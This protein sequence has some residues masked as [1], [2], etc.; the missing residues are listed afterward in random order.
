MPT[1]IIITTLKPEYAAALEQLQRASFPTL[2]ESE[3][4]LERHFL[5]HAELFP[6]GNFVALCDAKVV[7]LGSGF[8]TNFDFDHPDHTFIDIIAGGYYTNH[9]PDGDWYYGADISVHPDYRKRGIGSMLY[10]ARKGIVK[11]LNKKGIV[12]GGLIPDFAKH[13]GKLT[14]QAYVDKVVAG[15]LHDSTLSFQMRR[16]FEVRGLLENYIADEASDNWSTLIVW[17]NPDYEA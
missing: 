11:Q 15:E 12:A 8:L 1:N 14:V 7:G 16:G 13:K 17:D 10:T 5:K 4:M 9:D 3:L 6:E 2:A